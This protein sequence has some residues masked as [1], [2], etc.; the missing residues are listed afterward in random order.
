MKQN[1][2]YRAWLK[3]EEEMCEVIGFNFIYETVTAICKDRST[4]YM[5]GEQ[6]LMHKIFKF[7]KVELMQFTGL[8][9]SK[10]VDIFEG[11]ILQTRDG[12]MVVE[13]NQD[14]FECIDSNDNNFRLYDYIYFGFTK[15]IGNIYENQD[16]IK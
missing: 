7:D 16:L 1:I 2:K 8:V 3:N 4:I 11:D 6:P 13:Y 12:L 5:S 14:R 9:D 15:V 10:G